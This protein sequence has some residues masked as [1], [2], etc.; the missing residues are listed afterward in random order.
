MSARPRP[1]R[2]HRG[3]LCGLTRKRRFRSERAALIRGGEIIATDPTLNPTA[4]RAYRCPLCGG[5]H[6]TTQVFRLS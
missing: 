3:Y 5:W 6:L 4:F 2:P 1:P